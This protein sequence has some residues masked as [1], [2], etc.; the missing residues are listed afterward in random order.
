MTTELW[1]LIRPIADNAVLVEFGDR[2]DD[3]IHQTAL[4]FDDAVQEAGL[5]GVI[6]T[7]PAY[8]TVLIHYDPLVT[9]CDTLINELRPSLSARSAT[10]KKPNLWRVP[11]CYDAQYAADLEELCGVTGLTPDQV[12]EQHTTG[13]Y[14]VYMYGFAP[15]FA[16]LGGVPEALQV[17]RKQMPVKDIPIGSVMVAG[18]QSLIY[19]TVMPSGWWNIGRTALNPLQDDPDHPFLFSIGDRVQ[20][21]SVTKQELQRHQVEGVTL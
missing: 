20:F 8:T 17:P 4:N 19:A 16:Y 13:D 21:F 12:I 5:S 15:G 1:P 6:E 14:K 3:T 10:V 18:P 2:I 7:V 11:T 9:D